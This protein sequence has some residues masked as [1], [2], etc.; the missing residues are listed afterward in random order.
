MIDGLWT[1]LC[2][3]L[4]WTHICFLPSSWSSA[5]VLGLYI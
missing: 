2:C 5:H 1:Y 4:F 3:I